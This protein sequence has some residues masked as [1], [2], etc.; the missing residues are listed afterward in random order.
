MPDR[1]LLYNNGDQN[2]LPFGYKKRRREPSPSEVLNPNKDSK[3]V[4]RE[5]KKELRLRQKT[6]YGDSQA[7]N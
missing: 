6:P 4:K 7:R 1:Q 2:K 3:F 5:T